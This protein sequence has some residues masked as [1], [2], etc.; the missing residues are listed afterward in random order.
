MSMLPFTQKVNDVLVAARNRAIEGQ[1]PELLPQHLFAALLAPATGLRP[2]L[3]RAGL[4]LDS[5]LGM[6]DAAGRHEGRGENPTRPR[7]GS[8]AR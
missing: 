2:L 3:E 7:R 8:I 5:T 6:L 4:A 1:H